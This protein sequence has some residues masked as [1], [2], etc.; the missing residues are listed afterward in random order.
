MRRMLARILEEAAERAAEAARRLR[1]LRAR[2][3]DAPPPRDLATALTAAGLQV[4]AEVKRR[5]PSVGPLAPGLDAVSQAVR[6][7]D[8]GA[9]AVSV[10]TEPRH[11]DGSLGDLTAVRAAVDLPVLRKDF[12]LH[13]AQMWEARAAG[14]D[15]ALVIVAAVDDA[16]LR[17]LLDAAAEAGLAAL[18][19]V[20]TA[21]EV[22]RALAAGARIVGV[23]NRD[24][25]TFVTDLRVAEDLAPL[26]ASVEVRVAESG[27][28]DPGGAARMAAAGYHAVLVGEALV[29]SPDPGALLAALR[30]PS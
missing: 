8:G 5:S 30:G 25:S 20:H 12:L 19:E 26:L 22:E 28:S 16:A 23:N 10:L 29:R 4:I 24:L 2:A 11:F 14:A 17:S 13:P 27:V 9:A 18:V 21:T 3:G 15:A 6:Y 1:E 7:R